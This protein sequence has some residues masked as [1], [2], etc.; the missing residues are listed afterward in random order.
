M[1][2]TKNVITLVLIHIYSKFKSLHIGTIASH[3]FALVVTLISLQSIVAAHRVTSHR[4]ILVCSCTKTS[5]LNCSC[6]GG[7]SCMRVII[8]PMGTTWVTI[9]CIH[10][11][12]ILNSKRVKIKNQIN[13]AHQN[14]ISFCR[15]FYISLGYDQIHRL[16]K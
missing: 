9:V 10:T 4:S 14:Y 3:C 16:S 1:F 2:H 8:S 15:T 5:Y 6:R 13:Q 11:A 12:V 7:D